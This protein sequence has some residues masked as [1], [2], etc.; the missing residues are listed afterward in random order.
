M[1]NKIPFE[2][3]F[4]EE[5]WTYLGDKDTWIVVCEDW[6]DAPFDYI[7]KACGCVFRTEEEALEYLPVKYKMLTG[8]D[9]SDKNAEED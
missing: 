3:K 5:Y 7:H 9:W 6:T 1:D 4:G 8:R 2:P